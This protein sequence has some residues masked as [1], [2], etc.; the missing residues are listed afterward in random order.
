MK[1]NKTEYARENRLPV[2]GITG[3]VGAGKSVVM[4]MLEKDFHAGVILADLVAHELMEPGAVSYEQIVQE[5]GTAVLAKDRTIDRGAL[6]TMVFGHPERL[7]K[8]NEITHPN[9]KKEIIS[10]IE[11]M[12]QEKEVSFIAVE[13]AL[14][15]EGGYEELLDTLWYVYADEK[16]RIERLMQNRG[17]SEEKSR[18][19][20][21]RQL[22]EDRFR[23]HCPVVIDN[24][25]GLKELHE[26]LAREILSL[27]EKDSVI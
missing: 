2:I 20:M 10:R 3:G 17:Y 21:K 1:R 13:A 6:S 9:V 7:K 23:E 11:R 12:Q 4:G 15:I 25:H 22:K 26:Q 16:T 18:A 19:I 8:L 5:F 24:S 14:L 27:R